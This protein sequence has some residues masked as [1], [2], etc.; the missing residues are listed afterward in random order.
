MYTMK[1]CTNPT[2]CGVQNHRVGT[3]CLASRGA[4]N[5]HSG[6]DAALTTPPSQAQHNTESY[7]EAQFGLDWPTLNIDG[8]DV[9]IDNDQAI[10]RSMAQS[11]S[12]N[13]YDAVMKYSSG[14]HF[15]SI[16]EAYREGRPYPLD[17]GSDLTSSLDSAMDSSYLSTDSKLY[18]IIQVEPQ[19][20][21]NLEAGSEVNHD[22]YI[23]TTTDHSSAKAYGKTPG[24]Q[25]QRPVMLEILAPSG[26]RAM[27]GAPG[28]KE[29][30]L[31]PD[32]E[33][34]VVRKSQLPQYTLVV[35]ELR[36]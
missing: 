17:D 12:A 7:D 14:E 27:S 20:V 36:N 35:V 5:P 13:E 21:D 23:S 31:P 26:S 3:T 4:G 24:R 16:R 28:L 32:S 11:L 15:F 30:I 33:M 6:S 1:P 22:F 19:W 25:G 34:T 8:R 29:V 18:R 2:I 10:G 9:R